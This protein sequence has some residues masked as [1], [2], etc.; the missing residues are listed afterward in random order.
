MP[1][2]VRLLMRPDTEL[3]VFVPGLLGPVRGVPASM[4]EPPDLTAMPL[5]WSRGS[6]RPDQQDDDGSPETTLLDD[7]GMAR[8]GELPGAALSLLGEN[9]SLP[10]AATVLRADPV[11]A[12]AGTSDLHHD[13]G[14]VQP[15]T[16]A[17]IHRLCGDFNEV[18][19]SDGWT[20]HAPA[21]STLYLC[22]RHALSVRTTPLSKTIGTALSACMPGGEDGARLRALINEVQMWLFEHPLNQ[23]REQRGEAVINGLWP[24]GAGEPAAATRS[25]VAVWAHDPFWRGVG[26]HAGA[27]ADALPDHPGHV[28]DEA[29][30]PGQTIV[31]LDQVW[32]SV[33]RGDVEAWQAAL[34]EVDREWL[35]SAYK[36]IRQG[37]LDA[38]VLW[39]PPAGA[40]RLDRRGL[41]R[42]WR[43]LRSP[44]ARLVDG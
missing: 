5:W 33:C 36:A 3:C 22:A 25:P 29:L 24:W 35:Q 9:G 38:V 31:V 39:S 34:A 19:A 13:P 7:L 42:F 44:G 12:W 2:R 21:S 20:L 32:T 17:E 30:A 11:H 41:R 15:V 18:F 14:A 40:F 27:V 4:L 43:R 26:R 37:R 10:A 23:A 28:L 8:R 1:A 6:H 16:A